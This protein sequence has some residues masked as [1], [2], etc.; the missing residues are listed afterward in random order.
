MQ[1]KRFYRLAAALCGM[2]LASSGPA[3]AVCLAPPGDI[4][5]DGSADVIDVQCAILVSLW[6]LG[7]ATGAPP[8]CVPADP[9]ANVDLNCDGATNVVDV[10]TAI[11]LAL[12]VP[13]SPSIDADG[14]GCPDGCDP[15]G[16][17]A[18][19]LAGGESCTTCPDDCGPCAA[20]DCC[21]AS[22]NLG[23]GDGECVGCV[24]AL[25]PACCTVGWDS[26]CKQLAHAECNGAWS[27]ASVALW[28]ASVVPPS[29]AAAAGW[30]RLVVVGD[31]LYA[32][33]EVDAAQPVTALDVHAGAPGATGPVVVDLGPPQT[34]LGAYAAPLAPGQAASLL[35]GP[36]YLDVH[37]A[38]HPDGVARG[39]IV[40]QAHGGCGC[41][42]DCCS[43]FGKPGCPTS[44][45]CQGCVCDLD[46]FC[47]TGAWDASCAAVAKD[48]CATACGCAGGLGAC[49]LSAGQCAETDEGTCAAAS[50][51]WSAGAT[52]ADANGDGTADACSTDFSTDC[53]HQ[54]AAP[55]CGDAAC[56]SCVCHNDPYCCATAWDAL[57]VRCTNGGGCNGGGDCQA[58]CGCPVLGGCCEPT[59]GIAGCLHAACEQCVCAMDPYCCDSQ[60]DVT[61]TSEAAGACAADCGCAPVECCEGGTICSADIPAQACTFLGGTVV[62]SCDDANGNG[63]PDACEPF[64][65]GA[66]C[67][68]DGTCTM[69]LSTVCAASGG[70]PNLDAACGDAGACPAAFE[71]CCTSHGAP[72]C[73]RP[74]CTACVCAADSY[75]CATSWDSLCI[76]AATGPGCAA[77]CGCPTDCCI[78]NPGG[79]AGCTDSACQT[80]VCA[81][82]SF[83]C[84]DAWDAFCADEAA[85]PAVCGGTCGCPG[86]GACCMDTNGA[87]SCVDNW[88]AAHCESKGGAFAAG[89]TCADA[90]TNGTADVCEPK[91][92]CCQTHAGQGCADDACETCVCGADPYCCTAAWDLACT[93]CAAGGPGR[94]GACVGTDC[95][96]ACG[97]AIACCLPDGTCDTT[98]T[99][100]GCQAAG[101]APHPGATCADDNGNGAAD[102]CE[103]PAMVC[104]LPD[105]SCD[106]TLDATVCASSAGGVPMPAA[107]C[108]DANG[109][110]QPDACETFSW[111]A[112]CTAD[113]GCTV[114]TSDA[115]TQL[116]GWLVAGATCEDANGDGIAD[117]CP[118]AGGD[119]CGEHASTPGCNLPACALCVCNA[120]P[121]CC[122]TG[123]DTDC[124]DCALGGGGF[125]D[126]CAGTTCH[127]ACGCPASCCHQDVTCSDVG[128]LACAAEG[129][130]WFV[131][132]HT[133]SENTCATTILGACCTP[134]GGCAVVHPVDCEAQ[135]GTWTT[136]LN[137][138]DANGD[139][140]ADAC[141]MLGAA[142]CCL[143]DGSCSMLTSDD[144][145]I[146][147]GYWHA[148]TSCHDANADG[149]PDGC[150]FG[151]DCCAPNATG[152]CTDPG[153]AAC[154][155]SADPHC[156]DVA[157][158]ADCVACAAGGPGFA[159]LCAASGCEGTCGCGTATGACCLPGATCV[160]NTATQCAAGGGHWQAGATCADA[161]ADGVADTCAPPQGA[162]CGAGGAC[163]VTTQAA[164]VATGG[165][166]VAAAD[167]TDADAN[168]VADACPAPG[169]CCSASATPGCADAGCAACVCGADAY[170]CT[171]AW[172]ATC[173]DCAA[174]GSGNAGAC[175]AAHCDAACG[176]PSVCCLPG[177]GC[178][179]AL[180]STACSAA[181]GWWQPG[182]TCAD[183]DANGVAD[184]CQ[185]T[186]ASCCSS[187]TEPGCSDAACASCVCAADPACCTASWDP[188]C[189]ECAT[190]GPGFLGACTSANCAS[191]C[192]CP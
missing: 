124:M 88:S 23:C 154:V 41:A 139:G 24:C 18:C 166:W 140:V 151:G 118:F 163:S 57:C 137:C 73:D 125:N 85:D 97:C 35:A 120:D 9:L 112:C 100:A 59:P 127:S 180:D 86:L 78:I 142:A 136:S 69:E 145:A 43:P 60:W 34:G 138:A 46:E 48:G 98:Q 186:A 67:S 156:C 20:T 12:S 96:S 191:T 87:V 51:T 72:G 101:G 27:E 79:L 40:W 165:V 172:D 13:L 15:C 170:C 178:D 173:V 10:N 185:P 167:C 159:G 11:S 168:G 152:G 55:G 130:D 25:D 74:A 42:G 121:F 161:N 107:T 133:C 129:G 71:A 110:G 184:A 4:T 33:A 26:A 89:A 123:W 182:G 75:C 157:W 174:G 28:P 106:A 164:C 5:H 147:G 64:A 132:G 103:T 189:T 144:C 102:A 128:A 95:A 61:C 53:C 153:C 65:I 90:D 70:V 109:N 148:A 104:C 84:N 52:C 32:F 30:A 115:C 116:E 83:C 188:Y 131:L 6:N 117:A 39:A 77:E 126:A 44:V 134:G 111:G 2:V 54:G 141:E 146:A 80:C 16:D 21:A 62:D 183:N 66:C 150:A 50:G 94:A 181:G 68:P 63:T 92:P 3:A 122:N 119:C 8:S 135:G 192:A 19:D 176:C 1:P 108:A 160:E 93:V 190:G 58:T 56:G 99:W 76:D 143:P 81:T 187:H 36:I 49:C 171:T 82:D 162:C 175:A 29:G 114:T 91:G 7:G 179:A 105:G 22:G 38:T 37:T 45:A 149:V 17:G 158:D 169:A 31:T 113:G 177:G 155:C 14:D 47:C